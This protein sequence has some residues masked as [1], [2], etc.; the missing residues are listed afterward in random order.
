MA[1]TPML[2]LS[3]NPQTEK[4]IAH[5]SFVFKKCFP[6]KM[7]KLDCFDSALGCR[8]ALRHGPRMDTRRPFLQHVYDKAGLPH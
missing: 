5:N 3:Q 4:I 1:C 2:R 7:P 8:V 6:V